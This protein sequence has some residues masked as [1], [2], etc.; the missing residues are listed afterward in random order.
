MQIHKVWFS[1]EKGLYLLK[2]CLTG[3]SI[4]DYCMVSPGRSLMIT[5]IVLGWGNSLLAR[6]AL[7]VAVI[8]RQDRLE[9]LVCFVYNQLGLLHLFF[10]IFYFYFC[11]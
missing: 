5:V 7:Q 1:L 9:S 3:G 11:G 4:L 8:T 10:F 2:D 6:F